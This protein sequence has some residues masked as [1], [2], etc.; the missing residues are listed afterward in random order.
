MFLGSRLF[1][2]PIEY[3]LG[4]SGHIAGVINPPAPEG[5]KDKYQFWTNKSRVET[6]EEW[7]E[8]AL[9]TAGSWWPHWA[10]WLSGHSGSMMSAR[11]PG[12]KL[13]AIED[14][15]GSFVRQKG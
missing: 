1:G 3:V 12:A 15:P 2:G 14:A 6:Y 10:K 13:G 7:L 4:G 11:T 8:G 5:K 9:E